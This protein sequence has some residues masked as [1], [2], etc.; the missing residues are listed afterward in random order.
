MKKYI[1]RL[2]DI[3]IIR[4]EFYIKQAEQRIQSGKYN[5][6]NNRLAILDAQKQISQIKKHRE[7]FL[8]KIDKNKCCKLCKFDYLCSR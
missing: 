8:R 1:L 2:I 4:L 7:T 3:E 6:E 5:V